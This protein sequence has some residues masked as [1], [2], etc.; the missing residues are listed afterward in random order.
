MDGFGSLLLLRRQIIWNTLRTLGQ[1]SRL[2]VLSITVLGGAIWV[3]LYLLPYHGFEKIVELL[4]EG[5]IA[6]VMVSLFFFL[7]T[8]MLIFSNGVIAYAALF[9]SKEAGFLNSS[10]CS[11][12]TIFLYK[13]GESLTFSSWAFFLLGISLWITRTIADTD[14]PRG[15]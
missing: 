5:S 15:S 9:R 8:V 7:L 4:R 6:D 13:M 3:G 14:P 1:H 10:P 12:A 2:K 11:P